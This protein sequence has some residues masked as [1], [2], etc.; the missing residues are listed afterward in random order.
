MISSFSFFDAIYCINL[1]TRPDRWRSFQKEIE[2]YNLNIERID[3]VIYNGYTDRHRNSCVGN[4][5]AHATCISRAKAS[6]A[7]SV[8]IFEDD[9][10]FFLG[11]E[12]TE[13]ILQGA[14]DTL[15]TNW[16]LF[17]LGINLDVYH[18]HRYG[19]YLAKLDGGFSTHAYAINS[20]LFD[21]LIRTNED[22]SLVHN[23][24]WYSEHIH[25]QYP[26]FSTLPLLCG[27]RTDYSDIQGTVMSSN[28]IF[29]ERFKNNLI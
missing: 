17:Y 14:I 4:H 29:L 15:P 3:G 1:E 23:D 19:N 8:F 10:Q 25:T 21:T 7:R 9:A 11:K 27:Q 12:R 18:A 20:Y 2:P 22:V 26:C 28:K 24:V 6:G 16:G 13:E 5:L